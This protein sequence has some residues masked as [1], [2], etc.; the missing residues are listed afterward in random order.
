MVNKIIRKTV[1]G[2][3]SVRAP[4]SMY[5]E[6]GGINL[7]RQCGC[8]R[9]YGKK[10]KR[11]AP[12]RALALRFPAHYLVVGSIQLCKKKEATPPRFEDEFA[13]FVMMKVTGESK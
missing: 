1:G 3:D 9:R 2:V 10:Y 13:T 7:L 6:Q 11:L 8:G 12:P 5:L 4:K